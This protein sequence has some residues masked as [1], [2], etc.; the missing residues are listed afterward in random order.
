LS[1]GSI[2]LSRYHQGREHRIEV[3]FRACVQDMQLEAKGAG[4]GLQVSLNDLGEIAA[5]RVD[6][7]RYDGRHGDHL[8]Q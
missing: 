3:A 7:D 4:R 5:G 8:A 6:K 2:E 1:D